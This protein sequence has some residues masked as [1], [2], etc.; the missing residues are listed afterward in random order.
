[1]RSFFAIPPPDELNH[2]LRVFVKS[3]APILGSRKGR[4]L[5]W[6]KRDN[7]HITLKFLGEIPPTELASLARAG[8]EAAANI[9]TFRCRLTGYRKLGDRRRSIISL[10]IERN[11]SLD[12]LADALER[13]LVS[14]GFPE[15]RRDFSAHLTLARGTNLSKKDLAQVRLQVDELELPSDFE[16]SSFALSE[17]HLLP[18]GPTYTELESFTL[19]RPLSDRVQGSESSGRDE[20]PRR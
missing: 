4:K 9:K 5:Q 7:L 8:Q 17:S 3:A 2:P 15:R 10:G 19:S 18:S 12:R 13:A 6:V 11:E 16:V 20:S 14:R 1:M